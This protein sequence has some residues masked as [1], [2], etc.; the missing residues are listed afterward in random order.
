M[1]LVKENLDAEEINIE[2]FFG[3]SAHVIELNYE[4]DLI[5]VFM[6]LR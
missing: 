6:K 2:K 3:P 4:Y 1:V 5:L